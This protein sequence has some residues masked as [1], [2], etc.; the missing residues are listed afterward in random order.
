MSGLG[1][2]CLSAASQLRPDGAAADLAH[3]VQACASGALPEVGGVL[4]R[5]PPGQAASGTCRQTLRCS[6]WPS[7]SPCCP[8]CPALRTRWQCQKLEELMASWMSGQGGGTGAAI[9]SSSPTNTAFTACA[10]DVLAPGA[11]SSCLASHCQV[12]RPAQALGGDHGRASFLAALLKRPNPSGSFH[13]AT[14]IP[15]VCGGRYMYISRNCV[16]GERASSS[17]VLVLWDHSLVGRQR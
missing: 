11:T 13:P 3:Q 10:A 4:G 15:A 9:K 1:R 8:L 2:I 17:T 5:C 14:C 6:C 16:G 12:V 7:P